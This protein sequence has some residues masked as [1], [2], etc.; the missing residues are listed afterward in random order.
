MRL[1]SVFVALTALASAASVQ[2]GF[3]I[4]P[5]VIPAS[6]AMRADATIIGRVAEVEKETV[7][8]DLHPV[9]LKAQKVRYRVA[10]IKIENALIGANGV[11]RVRVGFPDGALRTASGGPPPMPFKL[12]VGATACFFLDR[13][14]KTDFYVPA[15]AIAPI[16]T[17]DPNYDKVVGEIKV[18]AKAIDD[19]VAA[20]KSKSQED[21]FVAATTVLYRS[22]TAVRGASGPQTTEDLPAEENRLVLGVLIEMPWTRKIGPG[23]SLAAMAER[24]VLWSN[25]IRASQYGFKPPAGLTGPGA[26]TGRDR[27]R[28]W[29]EATAAFLKDNMDRIKLQ[30][31]VRSK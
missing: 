7:E 14:P 3:G 28:I 1:Q 11:T 17:A 26:A 8:A 19:P 24:R 13:H 10:V 6:V 30:R 4:P 21:R 15:E 29:D 20:L 22:R 25:F 31:V 5:P 12:D 16:V 23:Y 2:A 27:D 18:V 9:F